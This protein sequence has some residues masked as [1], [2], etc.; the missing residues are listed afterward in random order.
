MRTS[1]TI[2]AYK[3]QCLFENKSIAASRV[4]HTAK[5]FVDAHA[6][7]Q[8]V[9][10]D[11]SARSFRQNYRFWAAYMKIEVFRSADRSYYL[12]ALL[13]HKLLR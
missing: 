2:N 3:M 12:A 11:K 8:R 9:G 1:D 4:Y 7:K 10:N 13:C 6:V 5:K